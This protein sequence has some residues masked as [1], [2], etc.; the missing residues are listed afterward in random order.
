MAFPDRRT[1]NVVLTTLF[2]AGVCAAAYCARRIILIFIFAIFFAYLIDPVVK[3]LQRHSLFFRNLRGPAVVEVYVSI[4]I[5]LAP[6]A[7]SFAPGVARN[8]VKAMD[9]AP[10]LL[11]RLSTGD[12]A[13]DLRGK[14]GWTEE[15][16]FR[17]RFF[18]LKHKEEIQHLIPTVDR[19]LSNFAIIL[20]WLLL[21][22]VLAIFFLRDGEHIADVFIRLFFPQ[23]RRPRIRAAANELHLMLTRYI[24]AQV[25]LCGLSFVFYSAVLL[26][27]RFPYAIALASLGGLLEFIPVVGWTSTF[28]VIVGFGVVNHL[29]WI[30]MAALLGI[31]RVIQDYAVMPRILGH[32]LKI[33]PLGAIFAVLVGAELGGVVGIYLAVPLAAA[34]RVVWRMG[35]GGAATA[36][37]PSGPGSHCGSAAYSR[38][39]GNQLTCFTTDGPPSL[40]KVLTMAPCVPKPLA[41]CRSHAN[42]SVWKEM[43][44]VP[45]STLDLAF[46]LLKNN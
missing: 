8:T 40:V 1:A 24:R 5:L 15:Q 4:V 2:I 33:H 37:P 46:S 6:V 39:N 17:L 23:E 27:L 31:W 13:T 14:Y 30:W 43:P 19:Y 16:E 22:P 20:W 29:H 25:L 32:E 44:S 34:V 26:L 10:V 18:L 3:F 38:G 9:Q 28:A 45:R 41:L 36:K 7:Y 11:D 42:C 35:A 12:V 21:V